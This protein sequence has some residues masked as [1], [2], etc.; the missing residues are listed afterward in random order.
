MVA[1]KNK[2]QQPLPIPDRA[3]V[4]SGAILGKRGAGKSSVARFIFEHEVDVGHRC[5]FVD[6]MGDAAGI[7]LTP[8]G[9]PSRFQNVVI[10]GGPHADKGLTITDEDGGR[11]GK[12]IGQTN[13][14]F[15]IDLSQML[16]SEQ[17]R[18]M[19]GFA[20]KLYDD[21]Q[22]PVTLFVDEAHIFAPQERNEAPSM[23]LNRMNRL[24]SMGRKRGIF[25]WLMTQRPARINKN[26]LA[27][28]ETLVAMKMTTPRDI[29]AMEEWLSGHDPAMAKEIRAQL[30]KLSAGE[31]F[32]WAPAFD[33]LKRVQFPMHSTFDSGRTPEHGEK[34]G[35]VNL[36]SIDV[37]G[38]AAA[39]GVT[40]MLDPAQEEIERLTKLVREK[41]EAVAAYAEHLRKALREKQEVETREDR[42]LNLMIALQMR[43]GA[44]IGSR[45]IEPLPI[46]EPYEAYIMVEQPGGIVVP[47]PR[48][49]D[50]RTLIP[51]T[52]RKM[53]AAK[54]PTRKEK[55]DV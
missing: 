49:G 17:L 7:R 27:G 25:L 54:V 34:F 45:Q 48:E 50:N 39:F 19:T 16:Q 20:D 3:V 18:F 12:L 28:T 35:L 41:S 40:T 43:I 51:A 44:A 10:I 31:A 1:A 52:R 55:R 37:S 36:P 5:C 47:I 30:A 14:S 22:I 4:D 9:E 42:L 29:D 13:A 26:T 11:V 23:L 8:E 46:T 32:V 6:P 21:I 2:P 38:I 33:F 24:N 15:L 53:R